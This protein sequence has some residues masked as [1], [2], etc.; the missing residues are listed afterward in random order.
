[1]QPLIPTDDFYDLLKRFN[2]R[3]LVPRRRC[4]LSPPASNSVPELNATRLPHAF[5]REPPPDTP[6]RNHDHLRH[7]TFH[8]SS[9]DRR[10]TSRTAN[11]LNLFYKLGETRTEASDLAEHGLLTS[12][13]T[14]HERSRNKVNRIVRPFAPPTLTKARR[15]K[16]LRR[17]VVSRHQRG[18]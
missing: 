8:L 6:S 12:L 9:N 13:A 2:A 10:G 14:S 5:W 16:S 1:M 11:G 17:T 15:R 3:L 18:S 4:H 7:R